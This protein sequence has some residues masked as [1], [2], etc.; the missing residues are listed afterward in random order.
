VLS[1]LIGIHP[2]R[3]AHYH[4]LHVILT[5][6]GVS[7]GL[8]HSHLPAVIPIRITQI[9]T[10]L[11]STEQDDLSPDSVDDGGVHRVLL[12]VA[13]NIF[14]LGNELLLAHELEGTRETLHTC[15]LGGLVEGGSDRGEEVCHCQILFF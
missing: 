1:V 3:S 8:V 15:A 14:E 4:L 6:V 11:Q 12:L 5:Q 7:N 13:L 9:V 10:L 2:L